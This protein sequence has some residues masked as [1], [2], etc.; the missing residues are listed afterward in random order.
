[1]AGT[2][3]MTADRVMGRA[4]EKIRETPY[5]GA[6]GEWLHANATCFVPNC[7]TLEIGVWD[8]ET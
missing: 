7:H 2:R 6:K 4:S 3:Y 8:L 1:L 5:I